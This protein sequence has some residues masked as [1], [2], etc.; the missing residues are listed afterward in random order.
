MMSNE[1]FV[2]R[3][4]HEEFAKRMDEKNARQDARLGELEKTT[5][6]IYPLTASVEKLAANM[7]SMLREV[8]AQ[9]N[10]LKVL[11]NRDGEMWRKVVG[12][13]LSALAGGAVGFLLKSIGM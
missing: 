8:T 13:V 10:R 4:E 5:K 2:P 1:E 7:E 3:S 9:G 11:E 6:Q 12:F